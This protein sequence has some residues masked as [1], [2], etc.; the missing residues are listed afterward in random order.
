MRLSRCAGTGG[1]SAA[2]QYSLAANRTAARHLAPHTAVLVM[3]CRS[4]LPSLTSTERGIT[5][6]QQLG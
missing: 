3:T 2:A 4:R 5:T 1:H 6:A